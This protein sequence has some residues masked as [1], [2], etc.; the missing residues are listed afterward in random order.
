MD[1]ILVICAHPDDETLGLGGTIVKNIK[2]GAKVYVL[3]FTEGESG[4]E[5]VLENQIKRRKGEFEKACNILGIHKTKFLDFEDQQLDNYLLL[6]LAK[7]I[8]IVIKEW[9]PNIIY[10]HFWGDMNQDH[11]QLFDATLIATRPSPWSKIDK[12]L[13]YE[14]PS[15]TEWG[16]GSFRP[17]LF[18]DIEKELPTKIRALKQYKHEIERFPHPRSIDSIK[19]RSKYFGSSVGIKNAEAFFVFR[20]LI[21]K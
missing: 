10:T 11:R 21:R 7:E 3:V 4:A 2:K 17:N 8:E 20:E 1:K 5:K 19:N 18:V 14:T 15:S 12:I 16:D 13:C 6:K 9:K